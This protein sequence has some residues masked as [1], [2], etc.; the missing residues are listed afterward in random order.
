MDED[1]KERLEQLQLSVQVWL[2]V[3]VVVVLVQMFSLNGKVIDKELEIEFAYHDVEV[4]QGIVESTK[5]NADF[6][7]LGKQDDNSSGQL[8]VLEH[9]LEFEVA[10][11]LSEKVK[12]KVE[13]E[14]GLRVVEVVAE[15][16]IHHEVASRQEEDHTQVRAEQSVGSLRPESASQL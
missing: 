11:E 8:I 12:R 6:S 13:V 10:V 9:I 1:F 4:E 2:L 7:I 3:E 16:A 5:P 15:K 14:V